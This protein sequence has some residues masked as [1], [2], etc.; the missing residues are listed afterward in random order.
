MR[1][2]PPRP[3]PLFASP[4]RRRREAREPRSGPGPGQ[5]RA[6]FARHFPARSRAGGERSR[7][8]L[9]RAEDP[10]EGRR[11]GDVG[12]LPALL[13]ERQ[14]WRRLLPLPSSSSSG[15]G[16]SP[17]AAAASPA[18]RPRWPRPI[19]G[20]GQRLGP[21]C[22]PPAPGA[23]GPEGT[24]RRFGF[25]QKN[26]TNKSDQGENSQPGNSAA[27]A[28]FSPLFPPLSSFSLLTFFFFSLCFLLFFLFLFLNGL[29]RIM[30]GGGAELSHGGR[31]RCAAGPPGGGGCKLCGAPVW[32]SSVGGHRRSAFKVL[33]GGESCS[34][35]DFITFS[36]AAL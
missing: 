2:A 5:G 21:S 6:A 34:C 24:A 17:A 10:R 15:S 3:R 22:A 28:F 35:S 9:G 27:R 7:G 13:R 19:L 30:G 29:C 12:S 16:C 18:E 32:S 11:G 20:G 26:K 8:L 33:Y 31:A 25:Q 1:R 4:L 36:N 23:P 14:C